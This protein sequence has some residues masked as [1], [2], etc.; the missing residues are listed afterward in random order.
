M[1]DGVCFEVF[2]EQSF[3]PLTKVEGERDGAMRQ[4]NHIGSLSFTALSKDILDELSDWS[5]QVCEQLGVHGVL[6]DGVVMERA[7]L[8]LFKECRRELHE[9]GRATKSKLQYLKFMVLMFKDSGAL[10]EHM[11][12][13]GV[14]TMG[15][16][17]VNLKF[18]IVERRRTVRGE[19]GFDGHAMGPFYKV[20]SFLMCT[21]LVGVRRLLEDSIMKVN[22]KVGVCLG[23]VLLGCEPLVERGLAQQVKPENVILNQV[24]SGGL[25]KAEELPSAVFASY[26][27]VGNSFKD[28]GVFEDLD[29]AVSY[30]FAPWVDAED[31]IVLRYKDAYF[32][33]SKGVVIAEVKAPED[34]LMH[35]VVDVED[36]GEMDQ[37]GDG[38][39]DQL[40][41]LRGALK[42]EVNH[43]RYEGGYER[44]DFP[45]GDVSRDKGVCT[46]MVIRAVR[47]AG[48][49]LQEEL[50]A[51]I[52]RSK[53]SYRMVKKADTNIDHRRV[54]TLL[55]YFKRHWEVRSSDDVGDYLPGDILFMQTMGDRRPDHVGVV[56]DRVGESG[57]P[58]VVNN[59]TDGYSTSAMD[60][61]PFVPVTH[62]FRFKRPEIKVAKG[63]QGLAGVLKRQRLT[64]GKEV[65][66]VVLVVS[67]SWRGSDG[68][69]RRYEQDD[70][71][72]WRQ[73]GGEV[74]VKLGEKGLGVG[75]GDMDLSYGVNRKYKKVEGDKKSPAGVFRLGYAFGKG[76]VPP[77]KGSWKWEQVSQGDVWVDD[78]N[79]AS[80]NT[81][82]R[83]EEGVDWTSAEELKMYRLGVVVEHN[84]EDVQKGR[85]SAIFLH[86]WSVGEGATLGCTSMKEGDLT[87]VLGWLDASKAPRL[88]QVVGDVF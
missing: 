53:R 68:V 16:A 28:K 63:D 7:A 30:Q 18:C 85:G 88:V 19:V 67:D 11:V 74:K 75:S 61:L 37:D 72:R 26:E 57:L 45:M 64:L 10:D 29:D 23:L 32:A 21:P 8:G 71:L 81:R 38:I 69:L 1:K 84:T 83:A 24:D 43:A 41:I 25:V 31:V 34:A 77:Y 62:R 59:W 35:R 80:Y 56:V 54:K 51:D 9:G 6:L 73:V 13:L 15:G 52:K 86:T 55:P 60:L 22:V 20:R 36:W 48:V 39:P 65:K 58:L 82:Q 49:D 33:L 87:S 79:S 3:F 5:R 70:S 40:D 27:V 14:G 17:I 50:N 2:G 76:G 47:N 12:D 66:Q 44:L 4:C 46:D 42:T 78:V